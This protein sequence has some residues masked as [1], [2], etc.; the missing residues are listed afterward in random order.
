MPNNYLSIIAMMCYSLAEQTIHHISCNAV[1]LA[2]AAVLY[3]T[4][5]VTAVFYYDAGVESVTQ[6]VRRQSKGECSWQR[7]S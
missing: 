2:Q 5:A 1:P 7:L 4:E 3:G 6:Y